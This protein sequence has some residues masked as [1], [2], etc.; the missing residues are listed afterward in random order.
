M[1]NNG[2]WS[3]INLLDSNGVYEIGE[4]GVRT[5]LGG[6]VM[7]ARAYEH[8]TMS[9][10]NLA[11]SRDLLA[12]YPGRLINE[13]PGYEARDLPTQTLLLQ[14]SRPKPVTDESLHARPFADSG[15]VLIRAVGRKSK[16]R[17]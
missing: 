5:W 10:L 7:I 17:H 3:S 9:R 14:A 12:S 8:I 6:R 2:N 4:I 13:R 11:R 15:H 16:R 1:Q